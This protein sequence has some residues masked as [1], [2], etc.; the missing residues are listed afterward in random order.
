MA[1]RIAA[2]SKPLN[3]SGIANGPITKLSRTR[4]GATNSAICALDPMTTRQYTRACWRAH[5][6]GRIEAV[7]TQT[8]RSHRVQ[9]RCLRHRMPVVPGVAPA[10][11]VRHPEKD[12]GPG[13]LRPHEG[14][15]RARRKR[16]SS[17]SY[18]HAVIL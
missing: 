17:H 6:I 5:R 8:G 18:W 16:A 12:V 1:R 13:V 2:S 11:I 3:T 4:T 7:E 15:G 10:L 9:M 14:S